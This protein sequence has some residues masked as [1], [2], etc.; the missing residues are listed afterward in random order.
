ME[1]SVNKDWI[2]EWKPQKKR[3]DKKWIHTQI[4]RTKT[5]RI[6]YILKS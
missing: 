3:L 2:N 4:D 5:A 1:Q 6:Y